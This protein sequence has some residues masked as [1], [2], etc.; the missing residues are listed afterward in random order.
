MRIWMHL[1]HIAHLGALLPSHPQEEPL[2]AFPLVLPMG[3]VDSPKFLCA[4]TE[5][6]A[7]TTNDRFQS[8][9]L[10]LSPHRLDALADT[11]TAALPFAPMA[12]SPGPPPP[13]TR[14]TGA[15]QAPLVAVDVFMDDFIL[16]SQHSPLDR[17]AARRTLFECID[18]VLRPLHPN[19]NPHR[20][21]P[22]SVSKLLKGDAAWSTRKIILGLG[23][24][25]RAP[26]HRIASMICWH[27]SLLRN[28]ALR[29]A[30]GSAF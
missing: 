11:L 18:A 26:Y 6:I 5:S 21:E 14:S 4:V 1:S 2:V 25:H 29:A 30:N 23:F 28:G 24:R 12:S 19:D 9:C 8:H 15:L 10:A 16:L 20:R 7:D 22:N 13:P 3:W 27:P 17:L